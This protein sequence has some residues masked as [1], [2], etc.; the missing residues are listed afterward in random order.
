MAEEEWRN[1]MNQMPAEYQQH[2]NP[3]ENFWYE[4][5]WEFEI[6][7]TIDTSQTT[8]IEINETNEEGM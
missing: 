2:P 7:I 8:T 4:G 3:Y 6:P 5:A 1:I